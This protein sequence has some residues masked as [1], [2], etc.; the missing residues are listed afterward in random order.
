[1]QRQHPRPPRGNRGLDLVIAAIRG[2]LPDRT[3]SGEQRLPHGACLGRFLRDQNMLGQQP[4]GQFQRMPHVDR[5]AVAANQQKIGSTWIH[6]RRWLHQGQV[7]EKPDRAVATKTRI[8][9]HCVTQL[10]A[11]AHVGEGGA[12]RHFGSARITLASLLRYSERRVPDVYRQV[13]RG[14]IKGSKGEPNQKAKI[15]LVSAKGEPEYYDDPQAV[16]EE[17]SL[18]KNAFQQP[19]FF[20]YKSEFLNPVVIQ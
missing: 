10:R 7:V 12:V 2:D 6:D 4:A 18:R 20:D 15:V 19:T 17:S 1:M 8:A 5:V 9:A 14:S 13:I 16:P 11:G 3:C